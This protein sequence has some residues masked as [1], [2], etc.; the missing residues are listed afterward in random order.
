M[1]TIATTGIRAFPRILVTH[2]AYKRVTKIL[3]KAV[4]PVL[5]LSVDFCYLVCKV[6]FKGATYFIAFLSSTACRL[7]M[8]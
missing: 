4:I 3:E 5:Q 1:V 8:F 2:I 7:Y 6:V